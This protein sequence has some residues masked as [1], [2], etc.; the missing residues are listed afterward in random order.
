M[1]RSSHC[2]LLSLPD[3]LLDAI[4]GRID[5]PPDRSNVALCCSRLH[6]LLRSTPLA[7]RVNFLS[8]TNPIGAREW[9]KQL[10]HFSVTFT[11]IT[12]VSVEIPVRLEN[13]LLAALGSS[14]PELKKLAIQARFHTTPRDAEVWRTFARKCSQLT[15]LDLGPPT[16]ADTP[17]RAKPAL[18]PLD[19][20]PSLQSFVLGFVPKKIAS[21]RRC[22]SLTSLGLWDPKGSTILSLASSS[23]F[24]LSLHSLCIESAD[25]RD[26]LECISSF[27]RLA[28]LA[29]LACKFHAHELHTLSLSL[30]TLT[31]LFIDNCPRVCTSSV[32]AMVRANSSLSTLSLTGDSYHLLRSEGIAP[33]LRFLRLSRLSAFSPGV[34]ADCSLD[35][36]LIEKSQLSLE[37]LACMLVREKERE[38]VVQGEGEGVEQS[39]GTRTAA[40]ALERSESETSADTICASV[41]ML[42]LTNIHFIPLPQPG[43]LLPR[44]PI[45]PPPLSIAASNMFGRLKK[46]TMWRCT[47]LGE[48]RLASLLHDC[49]G[50]MELTVEHSEDMSDAVLLGSRLEVLT[51]LTLLACDRITADGVAGFLGAFPRL[52]DLKVEVEKITPETREEFVR[53]GVVMRGV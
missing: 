43:L 36:L 29:L 18:P 5:H 46:L 20:F 45:M 8:C 41:D 49:L 42:M 15:L 38:E 50:L 27:P 12:E 22:S 4:L 16:S 51:C 9:C 28:S 1:A 48:Q 26:C 17:L 19:A 32:A 33:K 40:E 13:R 3:E 6:R 2:R 31:R 30:Q 23:S 24:R 11:L 39:G 37:D 25:L 21:L 10:K 34:L 53:A 7:L 44:G 14:C 52:S 35:H 47:G